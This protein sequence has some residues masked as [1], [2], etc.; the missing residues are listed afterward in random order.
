VVCDVSRI[1]RQNPN[2]SSPNEQSAQ[3]QSK[4]AST[5]KETDTNGR[6]LIRRTLSEHKI[7]DKAS[8]II[9]QAW[10]HA[11]Q[12]QYAVYIRRWTQFCTKEKVDCIRPH[13]SVVLE[14][15]TSLFEQGLGY[16]ALNTARSALSQFVVWKN[17]VMMGAHPWV[18]KFMRGVYNLR[19]PVPR[20]YDTWNVAA[21]L[22]VLR[23]L[24]PVR[25]LSL[26]SL[27]LKT[28]TLVA[29]LLAARSQ[30]LALL[31]L[32]NMTRK[33]SK[34]CFTIGAADLKQSRPGYTPPLIEFGAYPVDKGL[35]VYLALNEYIKR[36]S[37]LRGEESALF[38]SFIKPHKKVTA[39]TISRWVKTMMSRA[40]IDTA[41]YKGHSLR[42]ASAS[43]AWQAGCPLHELMSTAGWSNS[44]TF[45]KFYKKK[46]RQKSKMAQSV[47]SA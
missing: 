31:D 16:S 38:I 44:S 5:E 6:T 43:R 10:K 30:T 26:Q 12:K 41:K 22:K 36:T 37:E 8:A 33:T 3:E 25:K 24:S 28:A 1:V 27:T 32:K 19:P 4:I 40:G 23:V 7:S 11:T 47:L 18:I 39:T 42:A 34:F 14:F 35:C 46:I 13:V 20:Y 21:L 17:N 2:Y 15:L 45:A 29:L 9:M